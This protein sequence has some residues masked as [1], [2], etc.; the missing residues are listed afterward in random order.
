MQPHIHCKRCS[1]SNTSWIW[2][3]YTSSNINTETSSDST[4][5]K[6]HTQEGKLHNSF[7]GII[8][9]IEVPFRNQ[10]TST[11]LVI[12][13]NTRDLPP[14]QIQPRE[15]RKRTHKGINMKPN[16]N[17]AQPMVAQ[18]QPQYFHLGTQA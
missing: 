18:T 8:N 17:Q 14:Q 12:M 1:S 2:N 10:G 11:S 15:V 3:Y 7:T 5:D 13:E 4:F 6:R 9:Q 16:H